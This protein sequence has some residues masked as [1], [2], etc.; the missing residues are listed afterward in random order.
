MVFEQNS[1]AIIMLNKLVENGV[2][3]CYL[4]WPIK[5]KNLIFNNI[6]LEVEL[7]SE[8][9]DDK[10]HDFIIREFKLKNLKVCFKLKSKLKFNLIK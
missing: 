10:H 6:N 7:I 5:N 9:E 8:K 4:Y 2:D 3:K 1:K